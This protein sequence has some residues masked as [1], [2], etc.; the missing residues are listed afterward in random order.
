MTLK[1]LKEIKA[2]LE[3]RPDDGMTNAEFINHAARFNQEHYALNKVY[4]ELRWVKSMECISCNKQFDLRSFAL[5][6]PH[7]TLW[8]DDKDGSLFWDEN[9]H[10]YRVTTP[11]A[12]GDSFL[13]RD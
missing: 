10:P 6:L 7:W 3:N 12:T 9:N 2:D 13:M 4:G 1:R 11:D 8:S 5:T